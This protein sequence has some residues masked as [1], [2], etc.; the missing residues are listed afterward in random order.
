MRGVSLAVGL[1]LVA[2]SA[3]PAAGQNALTK[4][5]Q[6]GAQEIDDLQQQMEDA[7]LEANYWT[8]QVAATSSRL[9]TILDLVPTTEGA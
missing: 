8:D 2:L 6:E 5:L 1:L 3:T 7:S 9:H 4:E